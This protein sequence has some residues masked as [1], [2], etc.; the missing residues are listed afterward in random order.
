MQHD[1]RPLA[2]ADPQPR[3]CVLGPDTHDDSDTAAPTAAAAAA[4]G[5]DVHD[6]GRR[7]QRRVGRVRRQLLQGVGGVDVVVGLEA[8]QQ[9]REE[10]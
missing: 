5:N 1:G 8:R 6:A 10:V 2:V 9:A 3:P 4:A 7:A